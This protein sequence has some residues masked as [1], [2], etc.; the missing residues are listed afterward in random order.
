MGTYSHNDKQMNHGKG[1]R[2]HYW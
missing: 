2:M 1:D